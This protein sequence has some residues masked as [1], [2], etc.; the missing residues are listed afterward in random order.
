MPRTSE[1]RFRPLPARVRGLVPCACGCVRAR[2][3]AMSTIQRGELRRR[4]LDR[5]RRR[6][7]VSHRPE[8]VVPGGS[9]CLSG[10]VSI[11]IWAHPCRYVYRHI[12]DN[13]AHLP[14]IFIV[15]FRTK[16]L[17]LAVALP[18]VYPCTRP[19]LRA[20]V[21]AEEA[22]ACFRPGSATL[23]AL[24]E[25]AALGPFVLYVCLFVARLF[26]CFFVWGCISFRWPTPSRAGADRPVVL[27]AGRRPAPPRRRPRGRR[28]AV[29]HAGAAR[30]G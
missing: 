10:H 8:H 21:P 11:S 15:V 5:H 9:A 24:Y 30:N 17:G 16:Q 7:R 14:Q 6:N 2:V 12:Y 26:F 29:Q 25:A 22:L 28:R 18:E 20:R 1:G 23:G 4:G 27:Q 19:F 3:C 13:S